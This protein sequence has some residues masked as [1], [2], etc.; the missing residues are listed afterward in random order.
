MAWWDGPDPYTYERLPG[1]VVNQGRRRAYIVRRDGE[2]LG[3][4]VPV[5]DNWHRKAGR[6]IVASGSRPAF[7][8]AIPWRHSFTGELLGGGWPPGKGIEKD[9]RRDAA[10]DLVRYAE[11]DDAYTPEFVAR[12]IAYY[13]GTP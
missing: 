7:A 3:V 12:V 8:A 1:D 4:V 6:L 2:L 10:D 9:R 5:T 13:G 11:Y